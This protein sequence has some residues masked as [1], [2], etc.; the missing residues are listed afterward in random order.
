MKGVNLPPRAI[1]RAK[2]EMKKGEKQRVGNLGQ[3]C[4]AERVIC[5]VCAATG[6]GSSPTKAPSQ[7]KLDTSL[8][9]ANGKNG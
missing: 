1:T 2:E 6:E 4:P 7:W 3:W 8:A 9:S 5:K